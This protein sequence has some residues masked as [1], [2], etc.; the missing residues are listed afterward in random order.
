MFPHHERFYTSGLTGQH[1]KALLEEEILLQHLQHSLLDQLYTL[2]QGDMRV[3][4]YGR[5][6]K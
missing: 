4:D 1:R 2:E 3:I 6:Y 5:K